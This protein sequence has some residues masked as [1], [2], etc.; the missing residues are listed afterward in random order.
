MSKEQLT[1]KHYYTFLLASFVGLLLLA[2]YASYILWIHNKVGDPELYIT[3]NLQACNQDEYKNRCLKKAAADFL[4]HLKL[5]EI[6]PIL[7][8]NEKTE[9][10]FRA[11]HQLAH[12]LG[13]YEY[14][15][16]K[17]VTSVYAT[18]DETCSGGIYHG[19]I[20]GYFMERKIIFD[21]TPETDKKISTEISRVCGKENEHER[22]NEY[23]NCVHGLGHA[24]MYV[25]DNDLVRALKLCD[26]VESEW[27][28]G[29]CYTGALMQNYNSF[30]DVDHPSLYVKIDDPLY[31]CYIL[32]KRYQPRCYSYGVLTNFQQ[33]P[34]KSVA[35][36]E[37][38]PREYARAC[39][40][41]YGV[42][43][44]IVGFSPTVIKSQC[45]LVKDFEFRADCINESAGH[46]VSRFGLESTLGAELCSLEDIKNQYA[47][48]SLLIVTAKT[49]TRNLQTL[50]TFCKQIPD[51]TMEECLRTFTVQRE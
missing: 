48:Y 49:L 25:T 35:L 10:Y 18:A 43:R 19:T 46:L 13:Q 12:Y 34:E 22:I 14:G 23:G 39:F 16:V 24:L 47:C 37:K 9:A 7:R 21:G 40:K 11:C 29:I 51:R 15:R 41:T 17:S 8:K 3:K 26:Y 30:G 44:S 27:Y 38:I 5:T 4:N 45:G 28:Q 2:A 31:P 33:Y 36:C 6:L 32:E 1:K 50:S 20:E 42:D